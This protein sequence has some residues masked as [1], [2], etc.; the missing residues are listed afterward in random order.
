MVCDFITH[1]NIFYN[2]YSPG[3]WLLLL[4]VGDLDLA[5][6]AAVPSLVTE[7]FDIDICDGAS[8][9]CSLRDLLSIFVFDFDRFLS[10]K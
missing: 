5:L 9:S 10:R 4:E 2:N 1:D 6:N 8:V 7:K 3:L